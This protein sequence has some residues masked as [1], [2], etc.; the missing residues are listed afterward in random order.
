MVG[1]RKTPGRRSTVTL[2]ES[3]GSEGNDE[4]LDTAD[5][6]DQL[7]VSFLLGQLFLRVNCLGAT[8]S[9]AAPLG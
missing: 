1:T 8:D 9:Y 5:I 3:P 7:S 2:P 6:A 4:Q